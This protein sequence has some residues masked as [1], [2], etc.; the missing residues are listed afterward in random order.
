MNARRIT[1]AAVACA[2][3]TGHAHALLSINVSHDDALVPGWIVNTITADSDTDVTAA[4]ALSDL[5]SGS[6][7]Q[8]SGFFP[9]TMPNGPGDSYI[10]INNDPNT[11]SGL[12]AG[13]LTRPEPPPPATFDDAGIAM[14]WF[15]IGQNDIGTGLHLATLTFSADALGNLGFLA[16]ASGGYLAKGSFDIV[17]GV[18]IPGEFIFFEPPPRTDPVPN[19]QPNPNPKP[20]PNPDLNPGGGLP[21]DLNLDGN[22]IPEPVWLGFLA[23]GAALIGGLHRRRLGVHVA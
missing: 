22:A 12:T 4:G 13:D 9:N 20:N 21:G 5:T 18:A 6:L 17:N 19:P 3:A 11:N 8:L 16:S 2:L 15:N 7:L 23:A 10:S 1:L 14:I